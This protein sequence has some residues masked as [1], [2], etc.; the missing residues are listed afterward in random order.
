MSLLNIDHSTHNDIEI[1]KISGECSMGTA[2]EFQDQVK[3]SISDDMYK[4]IFDLKDCTYMDSY[5]LGILV[6]ALE[7]S[8][9]H[10][11]KIKICGLTHTHNI[12][13]MIV[14]TR[15]DSVVDF[16]DSV[17]DCIKLYESN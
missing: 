2:H 1:Y 8:S 4:F 16:C 15:L 9:H 12:R 11:S 5:G 3:E 17:E 10:D 14:I 6:M 13:K 7:V